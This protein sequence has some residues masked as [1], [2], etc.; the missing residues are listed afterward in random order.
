MPD[1]EDMV[2]SHLVMPVEASSGQAAREPAVG[3]AQLRRV[4]LSL[5]QD[6]EV[7][8]GAGVAGFSGGGV[9]SVASRGFRCAQAASSA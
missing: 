9:A 6:P 1:G 5:Q 8:L 7:V 2:L 4:Q 3:L